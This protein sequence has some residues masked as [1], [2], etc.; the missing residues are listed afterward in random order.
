MKRTSH[1]IDIMITHLKEIRKVSNVNILGDGVVRF[2]LDG[3]CY[4]I[5]GQYPL[6][7]VNEIESVFMTGSKAAREIE[8]Q[9]NGEP[10]VDLEEDS[11]LDCPEFH[12]MLCAHVDS[13]DDHTVQ[14]YSEHCGGPDLDTMQTQRTWLKTHFLHMSYN[15]PALLDI[16]HMLEGPVRKSQ[17]AK[18]FK[19]AKCLPSSTTS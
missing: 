6:I 9:L 4:H 13:M 14:E 19:D 3:K 18:A 15:K 11:H 7:T 2:N 1:L 5:D 12:D 10:V 16:V 17:L 8:L